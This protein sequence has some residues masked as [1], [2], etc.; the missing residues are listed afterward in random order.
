MKRKKDN[1]LD[2]LSYLSVQL[3]KTKTTFLERLSGKRLPMPD[4]EKK[5]KEKPRDA[6]SDKE[7]DGIAQRIVK[8]SDKLGITP[9]QTAFVAAAIEIH[10]DKGSFEWDA[11][12]KF[13][14][15]PLVSMLP[16]RSEFEGLLER[17]F[18]TTKRHWW[19]SAV[20]TKEIAL[21]PKLLEALWRGSPVGDELFAKPKYDRYRFCAEVSELIET[22]KEAP[23]ANTPGLFREIREL[24]RRHKAMKFVKTMT[25]TEPDVACRTFFYKVCHD[26]VSGIRKRTPI[27]PTLDDIF[28]DS[29]VEKNIFRSGLFNDGH[30]LIKKDLVEFVE[31]SILHY[32]S[33]ALTQKGKELFF[34]ADFA[35][36]AL[37][38]NADKELIYPDKIS[39]R[40]L[41]F[42]D[43]LQSQLLL[44]QNNLSENNFVRLQ[45]R[46]EESSLPRG[47]VALFYGGPGTGKTESVYQIAKATGRAVY[48]VDIAESKS[49]F[50]GE[51]EKKIKRIFTNYRKKCKSERLKPILLF[52]E[53]DALFSKRKEPLSSNMAQTEN[54]IQNILLEEMEK[55][56]GIM[57]ATT[58]L[59]GNF[60]NAFARRFLFKI[61]FDQPTV[62][63]KKCIWKEKMWWL[64][65]TDCATLAGK[66][67]FSGGEI[68]NIARKATMQE[69]IDGR[70]P[71]LD[72]ISEMCRHEKLTAAS[73]HNIVGFRTQKQG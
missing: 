53:A 16:L 44:L 34:E 37:Q 9:A 7:V 27:D 30:P 73:R 13:F 68:D 40:K 17:R 5:K 24:E 32:D 39:Q 10:I 8:V 70:R 49:H 19:H 64:S 59:E 50:F 61:R 55:L 45:R 2:E 62:D 35:K 65:D 36:I 4:K 51:S 69:V 29:G 47:I 20:L 28:R 43:E 3:E 25:K 52:N 41:F 63:A 56:D 66:Y 42:A 48:Q 26:F 22:F 23:S 58:N 54:A 12:C 14:D 18:L 72:T 57:I 6:L 11:I 38:Q 33:A 60:D 21:N 71:S 1:I 67:N 46:L 15:L 31:G